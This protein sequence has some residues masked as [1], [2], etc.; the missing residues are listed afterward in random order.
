MGGGL[1]DRVDFESKFGQI[2]P[3]RLVEELVGGR[4]G[5]DKRLKEI[6]N[7]EL[8]DEVMAL[9]DWRVKANGRLKTLERRAAWAFLGIPAG[10]ANQAAVKRA[11]K[12]KAFELHP[13][14]GGDAER[15]QLLQEMKDL[16]IIPTPK[17][18]EEHQK[19]GE[20]ERGRSGEGTREGK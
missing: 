10:A 5:L 16:L 20:G 14:K 7:E 8:Q 17:E 1:M 13:D 2:D 3:G 15:F 12:K 6:S 19:G 18:L 4:N 11:F 9:Q